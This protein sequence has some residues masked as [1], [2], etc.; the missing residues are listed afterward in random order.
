MRSKGQLSCSVRPCSARTRSSS[1]FCTQRR[2]RA[3]RS[4]ASLVENLA[5]RQC[6]VDNA[7]RQVSVAGYI[8]RRYDDDVYRQ[9]YANQGDVN[10]GR[11]LPPGPLHGHD[12]EHVG[13]AVRPGRAPHPRAKKNDLQRVEPG[14]DPSN[15]FLYFYA[16]NLSCYCDMWPPVSSGYIIE[17]SASV[18][19]GRESDCIGVM[20]PRRGRM[21]NARAGLGAEEAM[22]GAE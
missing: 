3:T 6:L 20:L 19:T 10:C 12:H 4:S 9:V 21:S 17:N 15:Q 8:L 18:K 16:I 11:G 22:A 2:T 1:A 13:I 7:P 5:F 14:D